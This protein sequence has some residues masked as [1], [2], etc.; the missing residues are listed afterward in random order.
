MVL[1]VS[2]ALSFFTAGLFSMFAT[3]SYAHSTGGDSVNDTRVSGTVDT[4]NKPEPLGQSAS[5][6]V[7]DPITGELRAPDAAEAKAMETRLKPLFNSSTEGLKQEK[8][9][10]GGYKLDLKGRFQSSA[11]AKR[12]ADGSISWE[13]AE[14]AASAA[15]FLTSPSQPAPLKLEEK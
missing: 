15:S 11:V 10:S 7:R 9:A 5:V 6:I 1:R 3:A 2:T 14:D 4:Q 13:C 8:L 12:N